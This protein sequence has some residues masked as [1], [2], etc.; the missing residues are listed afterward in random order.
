MRYTDYFYASVPSFLLAIPLAT[1]IPDLDFLQGIEKLGIVGILAAGIIFF[2]MER[3]S[4][5]ARSGRRLE[6]LEK[7]FSTLEAKVIAGNDKVI[8]LLSQQLDAL[9]SLKSGQE[10]NFSRMWGI[11]LRFLKSGKG[12]EDDGIRTRCSDSQVDVLRP[13]KNQK[14]D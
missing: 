13:E 6:I 7:Q 10:E 14:E 3:R 4:F 9:K 2:V 8:Y 12:G 5:I 11:T 1:W